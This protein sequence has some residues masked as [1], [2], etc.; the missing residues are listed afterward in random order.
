MR[1]SFGERLR[2]LRVRDGLSQRELAKAMNVSPMAVSQWETNTSEPKMTNLR[3]LST[4]FGVSI[5]WLSSGQSA[6]VVCSSN[7]GTVKVPFY[8]TTEGE[9]ERFAYINVDLLG[10]NTDDIKSL[11]CIRI[12]GDSMEPLIQDESI[13]VL[14]TS[15]THVR[16]GRAYAFSVRGN[17]RV[18]VL[19]YSTLGM[20]VKSV[21]SFYN[22][23]MLTTNDFHKHAKVIGRVIGV[24]SRL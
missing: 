15:D 24:V 6:P 9:S 22:D 16:D 17:I 13:V 10:V 20:C 1:E 11:A 21:N 12:E 3:L 8:N 4:F 19:T 14:N 23:E 7:T 2:I 5:E 18:K